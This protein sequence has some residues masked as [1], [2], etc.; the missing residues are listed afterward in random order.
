VNVK[1]LNLSNIDHIENWQKLQDIVKPYLYGSGVEISDTEKEIVKEEANLVYDGK[2]WQIWVPNTEKSACILGKG[3]EWCTTYGYEGGNYPDQTNNQFDYYKGQGELI[4]IINK[5]DPKIKY[6]WHFE[7][8][9]FMNKFDQEMDITTFLNRDAQELKEPLHQYLIDRQEEM[10]DEEMSFLLDNDHPDVVERKIDNL[11]K[12]DAPFEKI[13]QLIDR[14]P[15]KDRMQFMSSAKFLPEAVKSGAITEKQANK[16]SEKTDLLFKNGQPYWIADDWSSGKIL[17]LFSKDYK[18]W[19]KDVFNSNDYDRYS[20]DLN[21]SNYYSDFD[22]ISKDNLKRIELYLKSQGVKVGKLNASS[23]EKVI[24]EVDDSNVIDIAEK[25]ES[26]FNRGQDDADHNAT[27]R[28]FVEA[29]EQTVGGKSEW[30]KVGDKDVLAFPVDPSRFSSNLRNNMS[31][32]I[33]DSLKRSKDLITVNDGYSS[34]GDIREDGDIDYLNDR[35]S[36]ELDDLGAPEIPVKPIKKVRKAINK[37]LREGIFRKKSMLEKLSRLG[38]FTVEAE[39]IIDVKR[40]KVPDALKRSVLDMLE[41]MNSNR[42]YSLTFHFKQQLKA[43]APEHEQNVLEFIKTHTYVP[44]DVSE[45]QLDDKGYFRKLLFEIRTPANVTGVEDVIYLV[46]NESRGLVTFFS[47]S[48]TGQ[49]QT[50]PQ[51][52]AKPSRVTQEV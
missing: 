49:R 25:L 9:Q 52:Y 40:Q 11:L 46:V 34:T 39:K 12:V 1:T 18:N 22:V 4:I 19:A 42:D 23:L 51:R 30:L 24:S 27:Y 41:E 29:I 50:T 2:N 45:V 38:G 3:T 8:D 15:K 28:S 36:E 13:K 7:S 47:K 44:S 43:R 31:E 14:L 16:F 33:S 37:I 32:L 17:D 5:Q 20:N 26:V 6:Q 21:V 48:S 10:P 35:L